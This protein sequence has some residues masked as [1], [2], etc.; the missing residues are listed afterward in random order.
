LRDEQ[1]R[2]YATMASGED[3]TERKKMEETLRIAHENTKTILEKASFGVVV[4]GRDRKIKWVNDT[5]LKMAGVENT[6]ILLGENCGKYLCPAQ[7]KECPI[8][9]KGQ[10]VDNSER[11]FRRKDGKEIPIIKTV[12]EINMDG[13]AVLLET[14]IDITE[15]KAAEEELKKRAGE[16]EKFNKLAVSREL[17]MI[18]LKKEINALLGELGKEPGYKIVGE[19]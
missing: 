4:I 14:F 19:S 18:E 9:D 1:G 10:Q 16:L 11:I 7:Q 6:D 8:L 3:I 2:I 13:E 15:R 5:A 12:I 17:K